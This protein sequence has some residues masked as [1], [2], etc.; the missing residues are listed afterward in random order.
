M[1]IDQLETLE[2]NNRFVLDCS[3]LEPIVS[4]EVTI[5]IRGWF[6][7]DPKLVT[8]DPTW[9]DIITFFANSHNGHHKHLKTLIY[10]VSP[11]YKQTLEICAV[12]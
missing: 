10:K 9:S 2:G 4:G 5:T 3:S 11:E 7:K 1:I 12:P 6:D 8:T